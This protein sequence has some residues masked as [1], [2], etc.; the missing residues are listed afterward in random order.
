MNSGINSGFLKNPDRNLKLL[1]NDYLSR[2]N[3]EDLFYIRQIQNMRYSL[4]WII[5]AFGLIGNIFIL[6]IF[7]KKSRRVS[8]NGFCFSALAIS[9]SLALIFMLLRSMLKLQIVGNVTVACKFIKFIYHSSL[10]ISSW[11]LV[12]LTIDRLIAVVF[13]FK[14][15]TWSKKF[16]ALKVLIGIILVVLLINSHLL[17]FVSSQAKQ[18][19]MPVEQTNQQYFLNRITTPRG[20]QQ[21]PFYVCYV[22]SLEYPTYFKYIYSKW[23][24]FHGL[25]Y[26]GLPF[27]I[28]LASNVLIIAKLTVLRNKSVNRNKRSIK[29]GSQESLDKVDPSIKSI[30]ITI[31]LLSVAF[32]FL[33]FTSPISIY[34]TFFYEHMTNVREVKKEFIKVILRYI[35]YCNNAVNFYVYIVLSNEFRKE[36][37]KTIRSCFKCKKMSLASS[38]LCTRSTEMGSN[39]LYDSYESPD[40]KESNRKNKPKLRIKKNIYNQ[41]E[42]PF[43]NR[44]TASTSIDA[45]ETF[46]E[47]TRNKKLIYYKDPDFSSNLSINKHL[48]GDEENTTR[49]ASS[50]EPF[51]NPNPT[52]V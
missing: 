37:I 25:I 17:I 10:Q 34:M 50:R 8:S 52:Y 4:P 15:N 24:V 6:M 30:Q 38:S 9:D 46:K 28:I 36:F 2:T 40:K 21:K 51:I 13:I 16:H 11:C 1:P 39:D 27:L 47:N 5:I 31:M 23:D 14:Y 3:P 32:V 20:R 33:L 26:G 35:G 44:S 12:L 22:D 42:Q 48:K 29:S 18:F 41:S 45:V 43:I 7:L 19:D 49:D